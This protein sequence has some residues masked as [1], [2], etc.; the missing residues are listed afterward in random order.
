MTLLGMFACII[1]LQAT[2]DL[3]I[4]DATGKTKS[5]HKI[6]NDSYHVIYASWREPAANITA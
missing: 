1:L 4:N 2:T 5:R 3:I 6:V